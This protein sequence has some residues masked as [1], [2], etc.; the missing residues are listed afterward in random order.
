MPTTKMFYVYALL[1]PRKPG[2]FRYG[3]WVFSH[4]PFY[5]GKGKGRRITHHE[6]AVTYSFDDG[7]NTYKKRKIV[8]IHAAGMAVVQCIKREQLTD[9]DA[10]ALEIKLIARIG[11]GKLG[12]LTNLSDG[13]QGLAGH[14][15]KI[16]VKTRIKD[17]VRNSWV[18]L[19]PKQYADRCAKM[20]A[21]K[22]AMTKKAKKIA[23]ARKFETLAAKTQAEK[24]A[25]RRLQSAS[26]IKARAVMTDAAKAR[27]NKTLLKAARYNVLLS[28]ISV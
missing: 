22:Q 26:A 15:H 11:R 10:L 4:E 25:T 27:R 1:D 21:S 20:S 12:P 17:S 8:K 9:A 13:G 19:T 16:S 5:I 7:S 28:R 6:K 14:V 3:R 23:L 24:E 18:N 2:P